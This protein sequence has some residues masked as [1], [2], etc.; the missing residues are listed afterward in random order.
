MDRFGCSLGAQSA[1]NERRRLDRRRGTS[2]KIIGLNVLQQY[3]AG[4]LKD[5]AKSIGGKHPESLIS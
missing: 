4:S 1:A 5:A 2:E 3:F